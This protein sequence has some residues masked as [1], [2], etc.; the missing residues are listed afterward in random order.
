AP[1]VSSAARPRVLPVLDAE[2][3]NIRAALDWTRDTPGQ[4]ALHHRI[5]GRLWWYWVHRILWDE[6]LNR[7][8]A[9]ITLDEGVEP[10]ALAD[11]LYGAGFLAW[12]SGVMLQARVWLER[13]VELRR[14]VGE[15]GPLGMAI[16][17]L[18]QALCDL[19]E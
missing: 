5:V 1:R 18:G 7:L 2:H 14:K 12:V 6:G 17:A 3:D 13:A 9:A 4:T 15:P 8:S 19:G 10:A 11:T 16:C